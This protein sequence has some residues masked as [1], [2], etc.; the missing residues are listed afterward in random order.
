MLSHTPLSGSAQT[1]AVIGQQTLPQ[2]RS[3]GQHAPP[4]QAS[5]VGHGQSPPQRWF[6]SQAHRPFWHTLLPGQGQALPQ[7]T[8]SQAHSP[9]WQTLP[10]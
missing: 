10:S 7:L 2:A 9:F 4:T 1:G 5:P 8:P 3:F 6:V